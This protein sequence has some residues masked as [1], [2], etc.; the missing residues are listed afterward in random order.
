MRKGVK[1]FPENKT[2]FSLFRD[3]VHL[4]TNTLYSNYISC[5]IKKEHPL[6][7]YSYQ[8]R[9][10]M[11]NIHEKYKNELKPQKLFVNVTIVMEYVNNLQTSLLM[12]SLNYNIKKHQD[13]ITKNI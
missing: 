8:Y 3:Q 11:F 1:L 12:H 13:D 7:E 2:E 4:F 5:Y 6:K 10:H 9:N